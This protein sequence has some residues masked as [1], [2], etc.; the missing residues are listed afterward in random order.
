MCMQCS[1]TQWWCS[2][3]CS[4]F[5]FFPLLVLLL[6]L[7][8]AACQ[9]LLSLKKVIVVLQCYYDYVLLCTILYCVLLQQSKE[10]IEGGKALLQNNCIFLISKGDGKLSH[11]CII[12]STYY[13]TYTNIH[14]NTVAVFILYIIKGWD[15][16][17]DDLLPSS[18]LHGI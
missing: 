3:F 4:F 11:I 1:L 17:D 6:L 8:L 12:S 10:D 16:H 5:F 14:T 7:L 2:L 18:P 15:P 9:L 13:I